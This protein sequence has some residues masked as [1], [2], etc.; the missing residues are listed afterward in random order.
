[1]KF[2]D[3]LTEFFFLL[4]CSLMFNFPAF[5]NGFPLVTSDSGT[6]IGSGFGPVI[7]FD[8]PVIYGLFVKQMSM[9]ESLWFVLIVQGLIAA[10]IL[11]QAI[12]QF[13]PAYAKRI[14][15]FF[16]FLLISLLTTLPWFCSQIMPDFF[17][18]LPSICIALLLIAPNQTR[19]QKL[20]TAI[21]LIFSS[22][23]HNSFMIVNTLL[24]LVLG[25]VFISKKYFAKKIISTKRFF[26]VSVL[27]TACWFLSSF[28]N[29]LIDGKYR[30]SG[31]PHVFLMAKFAESGMLEDYLKRNCNCNKDR[32]LQDTSKYIILAKSSRKCLEIDGLK[33]NDS[34]RVQQWSYVN[35][36]NQK[37]HFVHT[38]NNVYKIIAI[39]SNKVLSILPGNASTGISLVQA[40]DTGGLCQRFKLVKGSENY[41]M[42]QNSLTNKFLDVKDFSMNNGA[43]IQL[44]EYTGGD[45]QLFRII[46]DTTGKLCFYQEQIPHSAIDFIWAQSDI[47]WKTGGWEHS[48]KEYN[49][50]LNGIL[51]DPHYF[52]W[53]IREG[54]VSTIRQLVHFDVGSG[55][56]NYGEN[57][58]PGYNVKTHYR[59]DFNAYVTSIQNSFGINL[60]EVNKRVFST[61]LISVIIL[62]FFFRKNENLQ[63]K[64]EIWILSLICIYSIIINAFVNG[65]MANVIDRLQSRIVW[66]IPFCV[67]LLV[68]DTLVTLTKKARG[69]ILSM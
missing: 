7:P 6:Y 50:V 37:F 47:F 49:Q 45:N 66:L 10:W 54:I 53:N 68:Y 4:G 22:L 69:K 38:G 28:V 20:F 60:T 30:L 29:F 23:T 12:K 15:R 62:L 61:I 33:Q 57:S 46:S 42:I 1:M 8:R 58:S 41:F 40:T 3:R 63:M 36:L 24:I 48:E 31:S 27:I 17:S 67:V 19:T 9:R 32:A 14:H 59:K 21:I 26:F 51:T 44:Y 18:P 13:L 2:F 52:L 55:L 25:I 11:S 56:L 65:S 34:A 35:G 43:P 16:I 64:K 5:L 39:H